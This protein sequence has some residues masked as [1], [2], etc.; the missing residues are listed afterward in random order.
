MHF[1]LALL[2]LDLEKYGKTKRSQALLFLRI[3]VE[4][5]LSYHLMS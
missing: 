1:A 5:N 3:L 2:A 4:Y